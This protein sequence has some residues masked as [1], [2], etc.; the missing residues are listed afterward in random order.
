MINYNRGYTSWKVNQ[1]NDQTWPWSLGE[2]ERERERTVIRIYSYNKKDWKHSLCP[3]VWV[4]SQKSYFWAK[5]HSEM[6]LLYDFP[7][8]ES[9][10]KWEIMCK[11]MSPFKSVFE[12]IFI[13]SLFE[14]KES[15]KIL[16]YFLRGK[17]LLRSN[18][19]SSLSSRLLK[20][21]SHFIFSYIFLWILCIF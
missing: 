2:R 10:L 7:G 8:N 9:T 3:N 6:K 1:S 17:T 18:K 21:N 15:P 11:T 16:R 12:C 5:I 4:L 20:W 14:R 13:V 19:K